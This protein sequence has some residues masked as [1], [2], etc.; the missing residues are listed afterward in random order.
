[1]E[2]PE[3]LVRN[4]GITVSAISNGNTLQVAKLD[5]VYVIQKQRGR[6]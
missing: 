5:S 4:Q 2:L 6:S 1:M 3:E